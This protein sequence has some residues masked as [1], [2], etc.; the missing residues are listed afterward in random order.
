M[1]LYLIEVC[2]VSESSLDSL[3]DNF[4]TRDYLAGHFCYYSFILRPQKKFLRLCN[5]FLHCKDFIDVRLWSFD[6]FRD[7]VPCLE[8]SLYIQT[9]CP[10]K[11]GE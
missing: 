9:H 2:F 4:D 8:D 1:K 6:C 11:G 7:T 3:P 5:S 10:V